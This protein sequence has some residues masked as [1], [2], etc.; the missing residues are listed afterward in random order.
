M[1]KMRRSRLSY[2]YT[3]MIRAFALH[4]Y[5]LYYPVVL[6]ADSEGSDQPA[7][8][9][10]LIWALAVRICLNTRLYTGQILSAR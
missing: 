1:G 2:A 4:R 8:M 3:W 7:R 9:R 5:I 10:R 6:L